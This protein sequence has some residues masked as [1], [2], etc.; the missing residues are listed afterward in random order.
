MAVGYSAILESSLWRVLPFTLSS[1]TDMPSL[2][3]VTLNKEWVFRHKKTVHTK[4][5]SSS[6]SSFLDIT[7]ALQQYLSSPLSFTHSSSPL[8][9]TKWNPY[10]DRQ[11]I[12]FQQ[13][14]LT[15]VHSVQRGVTTHTQKTTDLEE[16]QSTTEEQKR[17]EACTELDGSRAASKHSDI[18]K[19]P[20]GE[21]DCILKHCSHQNN[22]RG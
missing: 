21:I 15:I 10:A 11:L 18:E 19:Q 9:Q 1:Q 17:S 7:P 4:S 3:T 14:T 12:S 16:Q 13:T 5:S 2:T 22:K 20:N 8:L 6:S